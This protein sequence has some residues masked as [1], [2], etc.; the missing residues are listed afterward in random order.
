MGRITKTSLLKKIAKSG[1]PFFDR[2]ERKRLA[3]LSETRPVSQ[4]VF[5]IG[6]P[7]TG[8]TILYQVLSNSFEMTYIDNLV[9][10]FYRNLLLGVSLSEMVFGG[11]PHD[12]FTSIHGTTWHCGLRAPAEGGLL[13]YR[14]WVPRDRE[15][16]AP[17]EV[18]TSVAREIRQNIFSVINRFERPFLFKNLEMGQRLALLSE[19]APEA[20]I[21]FV[22]RNP[23]FA[24]QSIIKTKR[25]K[26]IPIEKWWSV[27]PKN[28]EALSKLPPAE[29]VAKQI[30][31][32]E[33]QIIDD[34]KRFEFRDVLEI[35][36]EDFCARYH[37]I[38][39]QVKGFVGGGLKLRKNALHPDLKTGERRVLAEPLFRALESE[40][41]K[42][43]WNVQ[44]W[45]KKGNFVS[46]QSKENG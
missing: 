24:G 13:W 39:D 29:M 44:G 40:V 30:Y 41:E 17:G 11:K 18:S 34:L 21:I 6:A 35:H 33:K 15:Y 4:P 45:N 28:F 25:E 1:Q 46:V 3:R 8:S 26:N 14:R 16:V 31:F 9:D 22:R 23:V 32:L 7:R 36:Y 2:Y 20:K 38:L 12:C 10:I 5:I 37:E 27:R 42:L 43:D 19:V